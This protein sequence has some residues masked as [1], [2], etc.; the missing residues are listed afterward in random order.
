M[1]AAGR[2][3]RRRDRAPRRL[4]RRTGWASTT[5]RSARTSTAP[6]CRSELGGVAGFPMLVDALRDAG[7]DD[8]GGREDHAR[9]LAARARRDV[10]L[11]RAAARSSRTPSASSPVTPSWLKISCV[12]KI[13]PRPGSFDDGRVSVDRRRG[14]SACRRGA[15]ARASCHLDPGRAERRRLVERRAHEH[16]HEERRRVP[17]AR[18]QP[19]VHRLLRR[20][21]GRCGT[22]AGRTWSRTR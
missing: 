20:P 5:S 3:R 7:Y 19:A 2:D 16:A 13:V 18:D 17:A 1:P 4:P 10:E 15:P 22:A 21:P 14:R 8:D 12:P 9:E 11:G 6:W